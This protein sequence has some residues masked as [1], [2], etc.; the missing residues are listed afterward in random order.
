MLSHTRIPII[1]VLLALFP[2]VIV[3]NDRASEQRLLASNRAKWEQQHV[4][5]YE[6]RLRDENCF[7]LYA[8]GY[9]PIRVFVRQG[10]VV[11]AIYEGET[12]DGYW[13]GRVIP[14]PIY[15][16]TSLIATIEEVFARAEHVLKAP[17]LVYKITYDPKYGFP[18]L[19][20]VDNPNMTDAQ[21]RLVVDRFRPTRQ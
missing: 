4:T 13:P 16:K 5:A 12:R 8:L 1:T 10:M 21:W 14:K 6:V 2:V 11:G 15:E 18:T 9:G 19:I 17:D 20:D 7:C 3:A